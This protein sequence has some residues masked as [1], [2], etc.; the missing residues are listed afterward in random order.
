MTTKKQYSQ[1]EKAPN[2]VFANDNYKPQNKRVSL[3]EESI[4]K[5]KQIGY[6][7]VLDA[8]IEAKDDS[9]RDE[10]AANEELYG[11]MTLDKTN[12]N[13]KQLTM[14]GFTCT[15]IEDAWN[16]MKK[17]DKHKNIVPDHGPLFIEIMLDYLNK[18]PKEKNNRITNIDSILLE[19][20]SQRKKIMQQAI[21]KIKRAAKNKSLFLLSK[22]KSITG[23][24]ITSENEI[25]DG[26]FIIT[27]DFQHKKWM[28]NSVKCE[29]IFKKEI[30]E[31][32]APVASSMIKIQQVKEG[33][34]IIDWIIRGLLKIRFLISARNN[35]SA[36]TQYQMQKQDQIQVRNK[37]KWYCATILQYHS[38]TGV[39][40]KYFKVRYNAVNG[41]DPFFWNTEWF[42]SRVQRELLCFPGDVLMKNETWYPVGIGIDEQG[43]RAH[44]TYGLQ[45]GH[46]IYV[47]YYGYW[48]RC[49]ITTRRAEWIEVIRLCDG[50]SSKNWL[51][52]LNK[53]HLEKISL[54]D[55]REANAAL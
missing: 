11:F 14:F 12:D 36:R 21:N 9:D 10:F 39:K 29:C 16:M 47:D 23:V 54:K 4:A 30:C 45:V 43:V 35:V 51:N 2:T 17:N 52:L 33:S 1:E 44:T 49:E 8:I 53:R 41:K 25:N 55:K 32:L 24:D 48:Y 13:V 7:V 34:V 20:K 26:H 5:H 37:N 50:A 18:I 6:T 46:H 31:T 38:E 19:K 15:Q 27:F 40:G 22:T 28:S 3:Q 42:Y